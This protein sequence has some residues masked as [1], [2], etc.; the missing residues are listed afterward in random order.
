MGAFC[1]PVR[2][3][4]TKENQAVAESAE[5]THAEH[6]RR[7]RRWHS[8]WQSW[9][10]PLRLFGTARASDTQPQDQAWTEQQLGVTIFCDLSTRQFRPDFNRGQSMEIDRRN[11]LKAAAVL[12]TGLSA[13]PSRAQTAKR[14][15]SPI[16]L[17][18]V[19]IGLQGRS[20]INAILKQDGVQLVAL[21]D[22]W[23]YARRYG[24]Y[25]LT[26]YGH[27]VAAYEDLQEMLERTSDLDGVIIASPDDVH[28]EQ[29][30]ACMKA[31]CHVYCETPMAHTA[32][33]ARQM[34]AAMNE[35][36]RL[37]QI[38]YQR[39]SNPRYR[40]VREKLLWE[41]Q[42]L[43]DIQH[44][45]AWWSLTIDDQRGWPRRQEIPEDRLKHY[46]YGDMH[47]FRNW[48]WYRRHCGGLFANLGGYQLDVI[49]WFLD[50]HPSEISGFSSGLTADGQWDRN[51]TVVLRYPLEDGD[52]VNAV[53][54]VA[55][56]T[57]GTGMANYE[58]FHGTEGS[59]RMAES[60]RWTEVFRNPSGPPWD[61]WLRKEYLLASDRAVPTGDS[62]EGEVS[63]TNRVE[64]YVLP[65]KLDLR[66][67]DYH[68]RNFVN[69]IRG[70][71]PL[72]CPA[73]M[74]LPNDL[75]ALAAG[76]AVEKGQAV[77]VPQ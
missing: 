15:G 33:A 27:K 6:G 16:R 56:S 8:F 47:E 73:D 41:A 13:S 51:H 20:L 67:L 7:A 71:E 52:G 64:S 75:A 69:A 60:P 72:T 36:E 39:R 70:V 50:G 49:Q 57:R 5:D 34:V 31:G 68:L 61:E 32:D 11:W 22:I 2:A 25:Y 37:L 26:R 76:E 42:L 44:I 55:T 14:S 24:T 19:G 74:A 48:R 23:E 62:E 58:L 45:N 54:H 12:T 9:F 21:C 65:W 63:E 35:T 53:C 66:P 43:G 40:N 28:A 29:A 59:L 46:G 3:S 17:G 4:G 18:L 10:T 38:G 30:I 77:H 1:V